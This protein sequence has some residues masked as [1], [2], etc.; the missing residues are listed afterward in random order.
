MKTEKIKLLSM[1]FV[2]FSLPLRGRSVLSGMLPL[3]D[4]LRVDTLGEVIVKSQ[5]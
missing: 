4:T 1:I 2:I 5:Y 3:Q